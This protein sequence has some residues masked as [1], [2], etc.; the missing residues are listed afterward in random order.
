[1]TPT[2][3]QHERKKQYF[4]NQMMKELPGI[5]PACTVMSNVTG[6]AAI[7]LNGA[8]IL[9]LNADQYGHLYA[10]KYI[11]EGVEKIGESND[12]AL[13]RREHKFTAKGLAVIRG[14]S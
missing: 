4:I 7:R 1:M 9:Y 6:A 3:Q 13:H 10:Q 11:D 8:A 14:G 5:D 12:S 2:R